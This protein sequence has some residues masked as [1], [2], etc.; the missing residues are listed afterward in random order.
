MLGRVILTIG[1]VLVYVV[2]VE[3]LLFENYER[4]GFWPVR[5]VF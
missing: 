4:T 5:F 1:M 2:H 3:S